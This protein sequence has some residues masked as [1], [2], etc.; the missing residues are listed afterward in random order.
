ME[1]FEFGAGNS[2]LYYAKRVASVT[3]VEHNASWY[4]K[5]KSN[6]PAN[7]NL[8][9]KELKYDGDYCRAALVN[10]KTYNMVI[11][12]GRDRVNCLKNSLQALAQNGVVILDDS[13][14]EEYEEGKMF[15]KEKGFRS[16]DF[17]GINPANTYSSCTTVFYK[18]DNCLGL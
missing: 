6:L 18:T 3:A 13:Q 5:I 2:T 16:I 12:D 8:L 4:D 9:Y 10:S 7:V 15:L 17:W 14:R 11:V 1:I